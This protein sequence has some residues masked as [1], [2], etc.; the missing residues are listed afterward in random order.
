MGRK[1][2]SLIEILRNQDA[3]TAILCA[4]VLGF[5]VVLS[6]LPAAVVNLCLLVGVVGLAYQALLIYH[7]R[8]GWPS[9]WLLSELPSWIV[10]GVPVGGLLGYHLFEA[11]ATVVQGIILVAVLFVS[12]YFW[13]VLPAAWFQSH[14]QSSPDVEQNPPTVPLSILVPAYNEAGCIGQCID[15]LV[16]A[17]YPGPKEIIV[18]DDGSTDATYQEACAHATADVHV[19]QQENGGKFS[20]LNTGLERATG[21]VVVTVDADSRV[22]DSTLVEIVADLLVDPS[23]GAVAGTVKPTRVDT[24]VEKLQALEYAVGINTFRRAFA[25]TD[26]VNVV[27]GCLG[28]FRKVAIDGVGGYDGD[29]MTEDYDITLQ[30]LRAGWSVRASEALVYTEAPRTWRG[31]ARQRLRWKLGTL[32]TLLKHRGLLRGTDRSTFSGLVFPYQLISLSAMPIVTL[33]ILWTILAGVAAGQWLYVAVIVTLF[34]ALEFLGTLF[35]L[36]LNDNRLWLAAYSP[37][38]FVVYRHFLAAITLKALFDVLQ[39]PERTWDSSRYTP[40]ETEASP[41][42]EQVSESVEISSWEE[43]DD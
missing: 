37:L 23:V 1:F 24:L 14:Q 43:S 18:I 5:G 33:V 8:D 32:E 39:Q 17:E 31:L 9:P 21:S 40:L 19:L 4:C 10:L 28:C 15:R 12:F 25:A 38:I 6:F 20:A 11:E 30:I 35:A 3:E 36:E 2:E 34:A 41:S 42:D 29:T 16:Q 13:Y 22:T 7:G 26:S 27:P